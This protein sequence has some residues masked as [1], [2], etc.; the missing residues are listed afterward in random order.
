MVGPIQLQT[1]GR[2]RKRKKGVELSIQLPP[3]KWI[4]IPFHIP[5]DKAVGRTNE[6]LQNRLSIFSVTLVKCLVRDSN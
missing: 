4:L 3:F 2:F 1:T 5:C 6:S